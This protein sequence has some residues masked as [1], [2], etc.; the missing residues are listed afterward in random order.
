VL[1]GPQGT[2]YDAGTMG[3]VL[4]YVTWIRQGMAMTCG[5]PRPAAALGAGRTI[6]L[7]GF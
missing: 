3:S 7:F 5:V 6:A 1:Q 4:R 2:L